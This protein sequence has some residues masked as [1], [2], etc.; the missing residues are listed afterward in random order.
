MTRYYGV[1]SGT[2]LVSLVHVVGSYFVTLKFSFSVL[3]S[4]DR[5]VEPFVRVVESY[6]VEL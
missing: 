3:V 4:F 1:K 6:L 5:V 2:K